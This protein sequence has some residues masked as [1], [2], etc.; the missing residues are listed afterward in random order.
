MNDNVLIAELGAA[1]WGEA[2]QQRMGEALKQPRSVIADWLAGRAEV[3]AGIWKDLREIT[4]LHCLKLS[5]FD[6]VI[7]R[8]YDDAVTR[9]S[10]RRP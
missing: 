10:A 1:V 5:D 3:P 6:P 4:R 9:A 7:V 8:A 2:W